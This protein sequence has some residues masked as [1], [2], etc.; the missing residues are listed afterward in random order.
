MPDHAS[1]EPGPG[2]VRTAVVWDAVNS[3]LRGLQAAHRDVLDVLDLGGGTGGF[4]V[5]IAELGHRVT[6]VDPS[7][8]AL[9]ALHRRAVECGVEERVRGLQGDA[10][11][12]GDH[13][14][15][16]AVHL[17]LCHGVLEVVD[18][19][20][21]ALAAIHR[22][23]LPA[24]V[25]SVVVSGR[26]AAVFA[27][28][29]AGDFVRAQEMLSWPAAGWDVRAHGPRRYRPDEITGL[30]HNSGFAVE[31][32]EA[33]RVFSDLVPSALVDT[34]AGARH[35]LLELE[36]A[37]ATQAD[38]IAIANQLHLVARR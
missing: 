38:F 29:L 28:A 31:Q 36:R 25:A 23:L 37:A 6:V 10:T 17:V 13:V 1:A 11:D 22:A 9:A 27:R 24:G 26:L 12:L 8:D 33:I 35:A 20:A 5:R 16:S 3:T 34:E 7:P 2:A 4:A 30:L 18:D 15:G 32:V 21:V 19:P 14:G